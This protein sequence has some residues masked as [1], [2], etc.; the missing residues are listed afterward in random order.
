MSDQ[1]LRDELVTLMLAGHETT[2]LTLSYGFYLLARHPEAERRLAAEVEDVLGGRPPA[3]ADVPHLRYAEWVVRE[4]M[5]LYPP[6][7]GLGRE[8]ITDCEVAGYH[9]PRGTQLWLTQWVVHRDGRWFAE[10]DAF[11]PERWDNDLVRRLPRCAYFPFGDG[12]RVCI[13]VN[14]AM[15]EAV[16]ILAAVAQRFRLTLASERPLELEPTI[17]LRP[18]DGILMRTEQ[19]LSARPVNGGREPAE[20]ATP[21]ASGG[22]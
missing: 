19:R 16:L 4:S 18:K 15:M 12:P 8:A 3:V 6:A 11:R 2:A 17:T 7:W 21:L 5:R 1:Q 22:R 13:G 20:T 10:P 14:F 9:V